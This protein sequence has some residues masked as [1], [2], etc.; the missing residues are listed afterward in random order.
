MARA[1]V[2]GA[3]SPVAGATARVWLSDEHLPVAD[4]AY[5][6]AVACHALDWDDYTHPMHGHASAVLLPVAWALVRARGGGGAALVDAF[7]A[8]YQVD[9]LAS[10]VLSHGHYRA[11][12]HATSTVGALGAAAVA[13][14]LVG[15]APD[16][17]G[18]ALGVAASSAAG[19]RVNFGTPTKA[20]H[21]G[22]AARAGVHAALLARSGA[23]SSPAWLTGRLGMA[24][25]M[26]GD[27]GA[28]DAR[29]AVSTAVASGEHGIE[30]AWGLAQK[31]YPCCGSCHAGLDALL[32]LVNGHDLLPDHL[33]VVELH[34]DPLVPQVMAETDPVDPYAARYCLSW[35]FAVAAVDRGL[36]P[37]QLTAAALARPDVHALR[38][39]VRVVPDLVTMD[40]DR[41][42]GRVVLHLRDGRVFE[43][44]VRHARGH[45][46]NPMSAAERRKKAEL[47]LTHSLDPA[48]AAEVL[49]ALD[50]LPSASTLPF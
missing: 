4:A 24:E 30:T 50:E 43:E 29:A 12:W 47:A 36:G 17:A 3:V 22:Q 34:V 31:P 9:F 20:L 46:D 18:H 21:A 15:L 45:P 10:L 28:S 42:A 32:S 33:E 1:T 14:R 2:P 37:A 19:L 23:C 7:L 48:A 44:T 41:Y 6:G 35:V 38:A 11:G 25:V 26:Q 27:R 8:G 16:E 5:V 13:A 39:R 49:A 40:E